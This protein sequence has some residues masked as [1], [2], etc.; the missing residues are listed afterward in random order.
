MAQD[1]AHYYRVLFIV[2]AAFNAGAGLMFMFAFE[3]LYLWMG[4]GAL[5]QDPIF[6]LF[7]YFVCALIVIF[8]AVYFAISRMVTSPTGSALAM[9]GVAG[10]AALVVLSYYYFATGGIP[11]LLAL[12]ITGD[13]I[14]AVLFLEYVLY[15]R[16]HWPTQNV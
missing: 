16:R 1:K 5:P 10:K 4:G 12:I 6:K 2:A 8:A 15:S 3:P 13:F 11:E 7:F 9:I 14:F